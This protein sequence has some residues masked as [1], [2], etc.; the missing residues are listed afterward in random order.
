MPFIDTYCTWLL[1]GEGQAINGVND[2]YMR[3]I[4]NSYRISNAIPT[5]KWDKM[6]NAT[7]HDIFRAMLGFHGRFRWAY[8]TVPGD[9][10][11]WRDEAAQG[12]PAL[13]RE[14]ITFYFPELDRREKLWREGKLDTDIHWPIEVTGQ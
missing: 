12:R 14:F 10:R 8:P 6:Q 4:I 1:R 7:T 2:P 9:D 11:S 5:L 3:Y 13:D